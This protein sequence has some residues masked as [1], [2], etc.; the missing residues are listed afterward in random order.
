MET[1]QLKTID[2]ISQE[3]LKTA[4]RRGINL[5]W[6]RY[7]R[8][9][10]QD[11]FLRL[12][13]SCPYGCLQGP[14][15][16]DPF[17]RGP[18]RGYCGLNRDGMVAAMLLRLTLMGALETMNEVS[19]SD[20]HGKVSWPGPLG[21]RF[22]QAVGKLGRKAVS[23][24]EI[25]RS[26]F[27]L[28]RP[29]EPPEDLVLQ[30][31]RLA[32]LTL[33]WLEK[34]K[35]PEGTNHGFP[36]Q[37]GYGH[38]AGKEFIIGVCG[39]PS[40]GFLETIQQEVS[41]IF[42]DGATFLSLGEWIPLKGRFL[43]VACTSGEAELIISSGRINLLIAGP[44]TDSAI[45][46]LGRSL[47]L[48]LISPQESK[49][50]KKIL[51]QIELTPLGSSPAPFCPDASLLEEAFV[52]VTPQALEEDLK[53][54][55][56]KKLALIGGADHP[57][58]SLG[59]VP[60]EVALALR[61]QDYR[62]ASWGDAA[63]WMVKK[64]LASSK[65]QSPVG[66]LLE[67]QGLLSALRGLATL[68]SMESLQGICFTGLKSCQ[69]LAVALGM[70]SLG[71]RLNIAVPLPLWGSDLVRKLL[72]EKLADLGGSLTHYDHPPQAQEILDWFLMEK[73]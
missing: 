73:R 17:G 9:Q 58:Q 3:L 71:L 50:A 46:E 70:A 14:C 11:G 31:L 66:I 37:V 15:R 2:P 10:P 53:K 54:E 7:E 19:G 72:E 45:S 25:S 60:V 52:S 44:G 22:F 42:A 59:W 21:Q 30:A 41:R 47:N 4:Y 55:P 57:Q 12:G 28:S 36:L 48:P 27:Y 62:V 34:K 43:S 16:I 63:L 18:D 23:D 40:P 1:I 38:L 26:A 51:R 69:D 68:G 8:L 5:S 56:D 35:L 13:L 67:K 29:A 20:A 32:L 33:G 6:D 24:E 39:Q 49:E 61:G 65:T 64:G